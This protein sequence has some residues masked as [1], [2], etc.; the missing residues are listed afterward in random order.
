MPNRKREPNNNQEE[1]TNEE[2]NKIYEHMFEKYRTLKT[3]KTFS[4]VKKFLESKESNPLTI[5]N[6]SSFVHKKRKKDKGQPLD[7]QPEKK[8]RKT[9]HNKIKSLITQ[10]IK[11]YYE[12][13]CNKGK[14]N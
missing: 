3:Q 5:Q 1:V 6:Y 11:E 13:C 14:I 2:L 9:L 7:K 10:P 12:S 8:A 4:N